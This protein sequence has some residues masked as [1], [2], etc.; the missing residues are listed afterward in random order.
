MTLRGSDSDG[1]ENSFGIHT[2]QSVASMVEALREEEK[3]LSE[4]VEVLRSQRDSIA[5]DDLQGLDDAVFATH[6]VL[7]T[8]G[9]ARRRRLALNQ[10]MGEADDLSMESLKEAFNGAPP[11]ELRSA[12]DAL[13]TT[14]EVLNREVELN[15]R[16]LRV[17]VDAGDKLVR[18]LCGVSPDSASYSGQVNR[19]S[20]GSMLDRRV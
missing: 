11:P 16:V 17:A 1:A 10:M 15:Q 6:R 9:E 5:S 20:E 18:A 7:L 4:L 2:A 19:S 3:M 12:I 14:G 13:A 8:L